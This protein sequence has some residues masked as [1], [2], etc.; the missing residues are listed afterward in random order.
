MVKE[1]KNPRRRKTK[2][3]LSLSEIIGMALVEKK[4]RVFP[5]G[6]KLII[7]IYGEEVETTREE[8]REVYLQKVRETGKTLVDLVQ[9]CYH[10]EIDPEMK[11][12]F[13]TILADIAEH[14]EVGGV[15][16]VHD[17]TRPN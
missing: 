6:D 3:E 13:A 4:L 8:F 15:A 7:E 1:R 5:R 9:E 12:E 11:E 16:I 17:P 10:R 2:P 14:P